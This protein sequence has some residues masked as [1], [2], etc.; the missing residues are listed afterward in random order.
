MD[1]FQ[2]FSTHNFKQEEYWIIPIH[3]AN[4]ILQTHH[5]HD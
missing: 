4:A 3:D 5:E 1:I 2:S